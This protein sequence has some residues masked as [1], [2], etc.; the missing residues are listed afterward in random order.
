M[1]TNNAAPEIRPFPI[2]KG[3]Q[4]H[5]HIFGKKDSK[6]LALACAGFP[7]DHSAFT[8]L[9]KRL[10]EECDCLVGVSCLPGYEASVD[11]ATAPKGGYT[12]SDGVASLREATKALRN[13][14]TKSVSETELIGIYHDWGAIVGL[15]F[16]NQVI[17]ENSKDLVPD[18]IIIFD[19]L[20]SYHPKTPNKPKSIQKRSWL[21]T[22]FDTFRFVTYQS[23]L[24]LAFPLRNFLPNA[25]IYPP[26]CAGLWGLLTWV[27][28]PP[29]TA[30]DNEYI[31]QTYLTKGREGMR[32]LMYKTWPYQETVAAIFAGTTKSL[33]KDCFAPLDLN[34]T[35]V[36]YLY[37]TAK[38]YQLHSPK[39]EALLK[40]EEAAGNKSR[41]VPIDAGHWLFVTKADQC[42]QEVQKFL[43]K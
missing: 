1:K 42:F 31:Y 30:D 40:Q 34:Q 35:P 12:L 15:Q 22:Y 36:L 25:L 32:N 16:S 37:G 17:E 26:L 19:V 38:P 29:I 41:I 23:I 10:A 4:G 24:A 7:D 27:R 5:L 13:Y 6:V 8:P 39:L 21:S 43:I 20:P 2:A 28:F 9:A 18:K 11:V 14:S 3:G 33:L